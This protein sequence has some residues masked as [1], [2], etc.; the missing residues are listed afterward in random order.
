M[1]APLKGG[2]TIAP[3]LSPIQRLLVNAIEVVT[4]FTFLRVLDWHS[5]TF[6]I[7]TSKNVHLHH[8]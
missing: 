2:F 6:S 3:V 8:Y 4:L 1:G 7:E 5:A